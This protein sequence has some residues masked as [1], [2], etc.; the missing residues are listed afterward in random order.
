MSRPLTSLTSDP[1]IIGQDIYTSSSTQAL[2]LGT[3]ATDGYGRGFR[4][5]LNAGTAMVP[6]KLYQAPA[7]DTTNFQNLTAAVNSV[8][9]ITVTT[10]STV[11]LTANQLAGGLLVIESATTGAGQVYRIKSHPAA[12][13]AV[14][15]FTLEDPIR[16]ATTGTVNIDV[17]PSPYKGVVVMPTTSTSAPVGFAVHAVAASEYGWLCTHG[18]T[19][20]LAQGTVTVGDGVIPAET[21]TTGAIV[22]QGNDTHDAEVGYALTGIAS[23]DYGLIFATID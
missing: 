11:T 7:E 13:A 12:S 14:V 18:P 19:A 6:G 15:T 23:G 20:A 9:D 8:D 16:V 2:P 5:V 3:Y 22:S 21:T 1:E 17:H 4:Y 10:T